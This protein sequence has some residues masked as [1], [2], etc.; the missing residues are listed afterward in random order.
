MRIDIAHDRAAHCFT[1][2]V[3][4]ADCVLDYTLAGQVMTITHTGVPRVVGGRGI[5]GALVHTALDAARELGW[6]VVP[7]CT[8]A[9]AWMQRHP[10]YDRLR[11]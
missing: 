8:Y 7:A 4:G 6:Q 1:A 5:A 3:D 2:R 9:A 11:A 10:E